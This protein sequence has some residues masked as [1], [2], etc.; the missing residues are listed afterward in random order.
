MGP[1]E[2]EGVGAQARLPLPQEAVRSAPA[3]HRGHDLAT[4]DVHHVAGPVVPSFGRGHARGFPFRE[5]DEVRVAPTPYAEAE[6]PEV[7]PARPS[8]PV[9]VADTGEAS[10]VPETAPGQDDTGPITAR[11]LRHAVARP[12]AEPGKVLPEEP[13]TDAAP[14]PGLAIPAVAV[15]APRRGPGGEPRVVPAAGR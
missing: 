15:R 10:A 9:G 12:A 8:T 14:S 3:S 13:S 11:D 6:V 4:G 1:I 7:H 5:R 2:V